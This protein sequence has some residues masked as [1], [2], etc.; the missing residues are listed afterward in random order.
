MSYLLLLVNSEGVATTTPLTIR[1]MREFPGAEGISVHFRP[2]RADSLFE[3]AKAAGNLAYRILRGEGVVRSQLWVEFEVLCSH[4]NVTGRSSDLLFALALIAGRWPAPNGAYPLIA[5]TGVLDADGAAQADEAVSAVRGVTN[6][7]A[8]VAAAVG[9][10]AGESDSIIFYPEAD[11]PAVASWRA[12]T[13]VPK[14]I[15][16]LPVASLE[17]ALEALGICLERVY[18]GNPF[19]GL[20]YFD[21]EHRAI[22][23]GRDAEVAEVIAQLLRRETAGSP[24]VLV[25]GASGSGKSSFLRAGVLPTLVNPG[26]QSTEV[27]YALRSRTVRDTVRKAIW[28]AGLMPANADEEKVARSILECWQ[29]LPEFANSLSGEGPLTFAHLIE[30]RR[31]SWPMNQRFVWLLDQLEELF[32]QG[33]QAALIDALGQFLKTLQSDGVWT[34]GSIRTDALPQ[35]KQYAS[36]REVFGSNEGQYYLAIIAATALDDLITRPAQAAGLAYG[37]GPAGRPLDQILR[38]DAYRDRENV[39]PLLQFTLYEMYQTRSGKNLTYAAY[40]RLGGLSGSVATTADAVLKAE[41]VID[42]VLSQVFRSLVSVDELGVAFRRYAP[43]S[44]FLEHSTEKRLLLQFVAARLCVTD[45]REGQAVAAFAHE[46]LLRTWPAIIDWL[47]REAGLLQTRELAQ[48][49]TRQWQ[50][51]GQS[52]DWLAGADKLVAFNQIMTAGIALPEPV[53]TFVERSAYRVRRTIRLKQ[54]AVVAITVLAILTTLAGWIASRKEQEAEYQT[55]ETMQAQARLLV[56]AARQRLKDANVASAQ[57]IILEVLT[58]PRFA[59]GHTSAAIS[60]FQEVRAA[61]SQIA[62]LYGH[63]DF[64]YSIF[65]SPDGTHILTASKDKTARIWDAATGTSLAV[66]SGHTNTVWF[67]AYSPDGKRI[68]TASRDGTARIWDASNGVQLAVLNGHTNSVYTA[69]YSPDGTR[70]VTASKDQ[71]ARI[72]DASNAAPLTA[73]RVDDT[74]TFAAFSPDGTRVVTAL[75]DKTARIWDARSGKQLLTLSGH[76]DI[77]QSALY[78][79]DNTRILTASLDHTARVWDAR[80]GAQLEVL[81]GHKSLVTKAGYSPDGSK[82]VTSS[83][84]NTVRVWDAITGA[85]LALFA[86]DDTVDSAAYSPDGTRIVSAS[87]NRTGRVWDAS[88][89]AQSS[90]LRGHTGFVNSAAYSPDATRIVTASDDWTART[91]DARTGTALAVLSGHRDALACAKYSPDGMRIVTASEDRTARVWDANTGAQLLLLSGHDLT[92]YSA[93][94]SPDGSRILTASFDKTARVWDATTG[95]QLHVLSGHG[96]YLMS[97]AYSPDGQRIVTASRDR[98]ARIWD[99]RTGTQIAVLSGHEGLVQSAEFSS[100]GM[101]IVTASS[102]GTSRIWDAVSGNQL[103]VLAVNGESVAS[104]AFQADGARIVTASD[105]GTVR[106]WDA[107]SGTQLEVLAGHTDAVASALYSRDATRIVSASADK[108]ARIWDAHVPGSLDEQINWQKAAQMDPLPE[109]DRFQLGLPPDTGVMKWSKNVSK[110]DESAGAYYDPDRRTPGVAI[111]DINVDIAKS[112]CSSEVGISKDSAHAHYQLG[113]AMSAKHEYKEARRE[114][115]YALAAGY[116]TS[117]VDLA[118]LSLDVNVG[119]PDPVKAILLYTQA[120]KDGVPMAAYTLGN[121]YE[122]RATAVGAAEPNIKKDAAEA[123]SWY[124]LGADVGEPHA[125]ARFGERE[126][127][128]ALASMDHF[129]RNA[130]LLRAFKYYA[131]AAD[132]ARREDWPDNVWKSWRYRR[133]TLARLLAREGMMPQVANAFVSIHNK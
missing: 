73:L 52:D 27:E 38:E 106:I 120:W 131:A 80:T 7:P 122:L 100:D 90:I 11:A 28:R 51:H 58:S 82:I 129:K 77:V 41:G 61:D 102:D 8:K 70:I 107:Q 126:E 114:F 42:P 95:E 92:I 9:A 14:H 94:Y 47:R 5:A 91:W 124:Q 121:L 31:R 26:S 29:G 3:S 113:R 85:Q 30:Q 64:V 128:D 60:T 93:V 130:L 46:A 62:V 72:W 1:Q 86:H 119:T 4:V 54:A 10:L 13:A 78:S 76:T 6:T 2:V 59:Q 53:R 32:T 79:P 104:A 22:F 99:A 48:R 123:W 71:T 111:E 116:R 25:E 97:A 49:E 87:V 112:A 18:L 68:V 108:T 37:I 24:G 50:L 75:A 21:Y 89:G 84:D 12:T 132:R 63:T 133:A 40:Q 43:M 117:R 45:Q 55:A 110:C 127:R 69:A 20:E 81:K 35:L 96:D 74:V 39:L 65:Y 66:L 19:R 125:L 56:D 44:E 103:Q 17:A 16:L 23:F 36:L 57:G 88:L 118:A 105:D 15:R 34:L 101:R 109:V 83:Q 67:A 33:L 98:T 115:E